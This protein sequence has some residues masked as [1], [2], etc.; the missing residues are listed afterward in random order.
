MNEIIYFY[1]GYEFLFY[2]VLYPFAVN[3]FVFFFVS[4][5]SFTFPSYPFLLIIQ[6]KNII[7]L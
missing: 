4:N 1:F 2:I 3:I 6:E 5:N 7:F